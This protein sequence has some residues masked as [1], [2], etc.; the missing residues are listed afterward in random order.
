M[1]AQRQG[2]HDAVVVFAQI[3]HYAPPQR[4]VHGEPVKQHEH[5]AVPVRV[6][7]LYGPRRQFYLRHGATPCC[8]A[9]L[10]VNPFSVR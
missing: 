7:V 1:S 9:G 6:F 8:P 5:R 3:G 4:P 2:R 10:A